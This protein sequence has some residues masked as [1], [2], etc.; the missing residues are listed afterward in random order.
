[1]DHPLWLLVPWL[2]FAV[3]MG[4]KV[5]KLGLLLNRQLLSSRWGIERFRAGLERTWRR[6]QSLR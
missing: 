1:M 3:G 6:N 4:S 2:V 5:W